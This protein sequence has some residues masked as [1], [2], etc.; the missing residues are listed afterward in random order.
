MLRRLGLVP[1]FAFLSLVLF[2]LLGFVLARSIG[3]DVRERNLTSART[4]AE[5][6]S[7]LGIQSQVTPEMLTNGFTPQQIADMDAKLQND[8]LGDSVAR[9]KIWNT[10]GRVVYSDNPDLINQDFEIDD[11]LE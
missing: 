2:G 11:D 5:L 7:R 10:A 6:V 3:S 1:K 9:I 8:V 4:L